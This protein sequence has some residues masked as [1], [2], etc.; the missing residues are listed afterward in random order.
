MLENTKA[1]WTKTVNDFKRLIFIWTVATNA[2]YLAYLIFAIVAGNGNLVANILLAAAS[3]AYLV[4]FLVITSFGK[5]PDGKKTL[6][7]RGAKIFSWAKKLIKIYQFGVM[8]YGFM[9]I[10]G[11][12]SVFYIL[13]MAL[14]IGGFVFQLLFELLFAIVS[15]RF[16]LFMDGLEADLETVKK[17]VRDVGNFFKRIVGK[18]PDPAPTPNANQ[19]MLHQMVENEKREKREREAAEREAKKQQRLAEQAA[20]KQKKNKLPEANAEVATTDGESKGKK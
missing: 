4:F 2:V 19:E 13:F 1:A 3:L 12:V 20:K 16:K 5:E 17:P 7:K 15:R 10:D 18:Q 9:S 14:M 6:K 8:L 11:S